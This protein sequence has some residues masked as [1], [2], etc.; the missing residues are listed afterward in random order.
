M[1]AL[2]QLSLA[3]TLGAT[4]VAFDFAGSGKSGGEHVSLGYYERDDLKVCTWPMAQQWGNGRKLSGPAAQQYPL[5]CVV[6]GV[7]TRFGRNEVLRAAGFRKV[8]FF[9]PSPLLLCSACPVIVVPRKPAGVFLSAF[10]SCVVGGGR[11]LSDDAVTVFCDL[12]LC[13]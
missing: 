5:S 8:Q 1:E 7:D 2:P 10:L 3:L 12:V 4:L 9:L 13:M 11:E 6:A